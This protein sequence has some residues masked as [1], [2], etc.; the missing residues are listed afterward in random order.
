MT[1][2]DPS[3]LHALRNSEPVWKL[4]HGFLYF[5]SSSL[6]R[7][8]QRPTPVQPL[9]V[10]ES[11]FL[12]VFAFL[13]VLVVKRWC[14]A[15]C[16]DWTVMRL[17]TGFY[18][19]V[20][21]TSMKTTL[22]LLRKNYIIIIKFPHWWSSRWGFPVSPSFL[23]TTVVSTVGSKVGKAL[24]P[25][26]GLPRPWRYLACVRHAGW[27]HRCYL[28]RQWFLSARVGEPNCFFS[29]H[30]CLLKRWM[31]GHGGK[32]GE[33]IVTIRRLTVWKLIT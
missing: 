32:Q 18:L 23:M 10:S 12:L 17:Q 3:S 5:T 6:L 11:L 9:W 2:K 24:P 25:G 22:L 14:V 4:T 1:L 29:C 27:T 20:L 8:K 7:R 15:Q 31:F 30:F 16:Q 28:Q 13:G 33:F 21:S 26:E 19:I